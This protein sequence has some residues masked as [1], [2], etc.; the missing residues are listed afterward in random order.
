M[1]LKSHFL[2]NHCG[3]WVGTFGL[4]HKLSTRKVRLNGMLAKPKKLERL[5]LLFIAEPFKSQC[6]NLMKFICFG[7][8]SLL[9]GKHDLLVHLLH[10]RT[11][12]V[13]ASLLPRPDEPQRINVMKQLFEIDF[14]PTPMAFCSLI[15]WFWC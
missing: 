6:W 9:G 1:S 2:T 11:T 13:C 5:T 7:L 12:D 4:Y 15:R 14:L 3:V 10:F 8:G